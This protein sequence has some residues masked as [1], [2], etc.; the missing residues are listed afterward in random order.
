MKGI[1]PAKNRLVVKVL[2][3]AS[4]R[5]TDSGIILTENKNLTKEITQ[6]E[7]VGI[8]DPEGVAGCKV[9]DTVLFRNMSMLDCGDNIGILNVAHVEGTLIEEN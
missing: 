9:G 6:G 2:L 1:N 7:V 8:N 4:E 3:R 5:K